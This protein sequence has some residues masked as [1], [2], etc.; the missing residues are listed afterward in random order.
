MTCIALATGANEIQD[1]YALT[2]LLTSYMWFPPDN[3]SLK[4]LL[5]ITHSPNWIIG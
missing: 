5:A 4:T 2:P 3:L 1:G